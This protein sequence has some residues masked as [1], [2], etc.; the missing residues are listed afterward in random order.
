MVTRFLSERGAALLMPQ[1]ELTPEKLAA[2]LAHA[3]R[4]QLLEMARSARTAGKP[5]ATRVVAENCMALV[6]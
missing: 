3:T 6:S 5:E 2:F 1:A 4:E